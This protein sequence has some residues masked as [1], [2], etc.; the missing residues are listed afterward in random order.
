MEN[1]VLLFGYF[2]VRL[3]ALLWDLLDEPQDSEF[4]CHRESESVFEQ[5]SY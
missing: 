4:S 2:G 1:G 5:V 3:S